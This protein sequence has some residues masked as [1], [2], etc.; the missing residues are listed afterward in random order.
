[1]DLKMVILNWGSVKMSLFPKK[2]WTIPL[3]EVT[4]DLDRISVCFLQM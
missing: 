1:M 3:S 4:C 2:K